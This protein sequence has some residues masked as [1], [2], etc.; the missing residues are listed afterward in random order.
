M[1]SATFANRS[2]RRRASAVV[3]TAVFGSLVGVGAM[4]LTVDTGIEFNSRGELQ[5]AADASALAAALQLGGQDAT[6]TARQAAAAVAAQNK[7]RGTSA[8]VN[9]STD[10]SFGHAVLS[11]AKYLFQENVQPF[12]AV[13]VIVRRDGAAQDHPKLPLMFGSLL[14]PSGAA[15]SASAVAMLVPRDIS[16]I[17][18]LSGSMNDDSELRHYRTFTSENAGQGT[19]P[20]VMVNLPDVWLN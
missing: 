8:F 9:G 15:I 10:V 7:V 19:R 17:V 2:Y 13:Q 20:G 12:D 4:A 3:Q 6:T 14:F 16:V 11:G 18:D 5:S 1:R